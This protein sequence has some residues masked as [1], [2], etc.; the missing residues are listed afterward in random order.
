[1]F[2]VLPFERK[3]QGALTQAV[4]WSTRF[5]RRKDPHW[6]GLLV[7]GCQANSHISSWAALSPANIATSLTWKTVQQFQADYRK[8]LAR[9][10]RLGQWHKL[11]ILHSTKGHVCNTQASHVSDCLQLWM[12]MDKYVITWIIKMRS[13]SLHNRMLIFRLIAKLFSEKP[14]KIEFYNFLSRESFK[15]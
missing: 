13:S 6:C 15:S 14:L 4:R 9:D 11:S 5:L 7:H 8:A 3:T 12:D 10:N 1:M 2:P